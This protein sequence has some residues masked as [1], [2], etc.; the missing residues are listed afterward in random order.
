MNLKYE[1]MDP[2]DLISLELS[3]KF[4]RPEP[5]RAESPR[6]NPFDLHPLKN[7]YFA[8]M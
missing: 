6:P 1:P 5:P 2:F 4:P 7:N 8:E 3:R